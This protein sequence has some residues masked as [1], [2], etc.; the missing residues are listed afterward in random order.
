MILRK[1]E[2]PLHL[3]HDDRRHG[4]TDTKVRRRTI[5]QENENMPRILGWDTSEVVAIGSDCTLFEPIT[6]RIG[7]VIYRLEC[8]SEPTN[9]TV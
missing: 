8:L 2:L 3:Q 1:S 7:N 5:P 9:S 6:T 4:W